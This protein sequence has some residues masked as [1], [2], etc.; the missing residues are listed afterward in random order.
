MGNIHEIAMRILV[1]DSKDGSPP[2]IRIMN[3]FKSFKM[4]FRHSILILSFPDPKI[5]GSKVNNDSINIIKLPIV[6]FSSNRLKNFFFR[7]IIYV[8]ILN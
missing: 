1:I 2:N 8:R 7:Y 3:Y 5:E 4:K 6:N